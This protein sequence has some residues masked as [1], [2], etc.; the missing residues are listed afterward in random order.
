MATNKQRQPV[1]KAAAKSNVVKT[2]RVVAPSRGET[3][4][5]EVLCRPKS[6]AELPQMMQELTLDQVDRSQP[7]DRT[8]QEVAMSLQQ[9][10]FR[11]FTSDSTTSVSAEGPYGDRKSVV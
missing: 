11:V 9:A 4:S 6:G 2:D 7:D 8:L 3:V 5:F 10:G 1:S